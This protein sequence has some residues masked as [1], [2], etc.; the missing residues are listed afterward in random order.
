M[1]KYIFIALFIGSCS[2]KMSPSSAKVNYVYSSDG[3]I[4]LNAIGVGKNKEKAITDAE[5]NAF[6]VLLFRGVPESKQKIALVGTNEIE[7]KQKHQTYFDKFYKGLR[8]KT[9]L[10]SSIPTTNASKISGGLKSIAVDIKINV[11]ALRK[12]LE[13]NNIIRKFGY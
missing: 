11:S 12:D 8:Y 4:T 13:Q 3:A 2:P 10:M 9:F 1:N 6:E 5:I 7:G